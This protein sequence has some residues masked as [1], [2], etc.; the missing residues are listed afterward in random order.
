MRYIRAVVAL[1]VVLVVVAC[2]LDHPGAAQN[3]TT[4]MQQQIGD[5]VLDG[6]DRAASCSA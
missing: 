4:T 5:E 2:A 6:C 1:S 3:A